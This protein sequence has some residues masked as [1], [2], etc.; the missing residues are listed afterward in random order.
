MRRILVDS[1]RARQRKKRGGDIQKFEI[2]EWDAVVSEDEQLIALDEA[3]EKLH[4]ID[5]NKARLVEL[6]FFGGLTN[7]EAAEQLA[8]STATAERYWAFSRAWLRSRMGRLI[9][10]YLRATLSS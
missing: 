3:L 4:E 9:D 8:I 10:C 2:K 1:A 7:K 6:R 5:S